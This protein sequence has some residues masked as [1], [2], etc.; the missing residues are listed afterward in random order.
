M[1]QR[2]GAKVLGG[3]YR[4]GGD[5]MGLAMLILVLTFIALFAIGGR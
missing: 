5:L 4:S 1:Q 2:P 3:I